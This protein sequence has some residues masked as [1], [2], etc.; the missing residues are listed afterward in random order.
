[1]P[2]RRQFLGMGCGLAMSGFLGSVGTLLCP[3]HGWASPGSGGEETIRTDFLDGSSKSVA[4]LEEMVGPSLGRLLTKTSREI[5]SSPFSVGLE[6]LDR[7]MY[8]PERVYDPLGKLGVKWARLQTGWARTEQI[9]GQYDFGWLDAVVDAVVG[10]GV[11]PWFNVG[12]GNKL[13][14]PEAPDASAVGWIPIYNADAQQ[15]WLRYVRALAQRFGER[16][17][18]WEIWNEPNI[19]NFW[20]PGE[21]SPELYVEFVAQTAKVIREV[22]PQVTIIGGALAGMP[23]DY[24][25]KLLSCGLAQHVDKIS[26]H[27]YRAIPEDGYRDTLETWKQL[28]QSAGEKRLQLW[29]GENGC[30]SRP[31]SAGA[32]AQFPWN[33]ITQCKWLLRRVLYDR[34]LGLELTSYF[35]MVDL[36]RYNWG[37]GPTD[38]ANWKGLLRGEDYSPKPA[39][40]GY[41]RICTL[42]DD[43]A[44]RDISLDTS[45]EVVEENRADPA[46]SRSSKEKRFIPPAAFVRNN[47]PMWCFWYA[48]DLIKPGEITYLTLTIR[49]KALSSGELFYLDLL[50][51][52]IFR[53]SK[54]ER[55]ND[56]CHVRSIPVGDYPVVIGAPGALQGLVSS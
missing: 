7:S 55:Q 9:V 41:Q 6:T 51:G 43:D 52:R 8:D 19:K 32:L 5:R 49:E 15:A 45:V 23:T 47:S 54:L 50:S 53:L 31:G 13:Y 33:E 56:Q 40:F 22:I 17:K 36:M 35:H 26:F 11:A 18:H 25:K 44:R 24:L 39:Y 34:V 21:P 30:P 38:K 37:Q 42:F 1:M 4:W 48:S 20:K 3:K 14:T 46:S 29:Q 28:L 2:N 10:Q 12:Y 27:P 16:V